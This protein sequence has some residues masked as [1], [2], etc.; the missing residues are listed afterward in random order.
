VIFKI[1]KVFIIICLGVVMP[2]NALAQDKSLPGFTSQI[3]DLERKEGG[4]IGIAALNTENGQLLEYRAD[5][6]F[7]MCS[8]FKLLLVAA[9]LSRVDANLE[10]LDRSINYSQADIQNYAPITKKYLADGKM[11]VADLSAA[12]IQY[13]DNTAA[14]L[15][16][17]SIGG[18]KGLTKY[19]R[20]LGDKTSR[21][22]RNEPELN[23]NITGDIQD[24]TT[25]SAMLDTMQK[26][27][28]GKSLSPKSNQ[29]L[30][31]WLLGNTTGDKK[32]RAGMN[33]EWKVGDKTGSGGNGASN[34]VAIVWPTGKKPFLLAVYY[35][36]ANSSTEKQNT[37]IAEIGHIVSATFYEQTND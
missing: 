20:T 6:R 27:L 30:I 22:D 33:Q 7:A 34:D 25:P 28:I 36:A 17:Q 21:L 10:R 1:K 14:N 8:T 12:A 29:Q 35:S 9:V 13:S 3:A 5:E 24:T 15:L 11:S 4:R 18:P 16:L 32:L 2:L 26:V 19:L 37:I 31:T 23:T